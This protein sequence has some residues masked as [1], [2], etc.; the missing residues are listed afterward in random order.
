ML[1]ARGAETSQHGQEQKPNAR[2]LVAPGEST[3]RRRTFSCSRRHPPTRRCRSRSRRPDVEHLFDYV[4]DLWR[5][6]RKHFRNF[7]HDLCHGKRKN[8]P[9]FLHDPWHEMRKNF[10][11]FLHDPWHEM[12]K[13]FPDFLHDPWHEMRKHFPDFLSDLWH[14][15]RKPSPAQY[16]C[17]SH[18]L[19]S[20]HRI[21]E[22]CGQ[23]SGGKKHR[24]FI[25]SLHSIR[26]A[27]GSCTP[28]C[29]HCWQSAC[30]K[31]LSS[32]TL[33]LPTIFIVFSS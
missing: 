1:T 32:M 20:L 3:R 21:L 12:R 4:F 23:L 33:K 6:T 17:P 28:N 9:D 5:E 10:A 7:L 11:D 15:I 2:V 24:Q 26:E 13:N 30:N 29:F 8:F 14:E 19:R 25:R 27:D 31:E 18:A 16:P 22:F